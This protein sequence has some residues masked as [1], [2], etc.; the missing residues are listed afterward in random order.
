M[1]RRTRIALAAAV[2]AL[3]LTVAVAPASAGT[4]GPNNANAK[5][6]QKGGWDALFTSDGG[7]FK[8]EGECV[9]YASMGGTLRT[10]PFGSA[11]EAACA[12]YNGLF[13]V[14]RSSPYSW[15][16]SGFAAEGIDA[17]EGACA[18]DMAAYGVTNFVESGGTNGTIAGQN[19]AQF[20]F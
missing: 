20:P 10:A 2:A 16:C 6:C 12:T 1:S 3:S 14:I 4:N 8:N 5:L 13:S 19:C 11:G 7:D 15:T 17:V 9:S 18:V